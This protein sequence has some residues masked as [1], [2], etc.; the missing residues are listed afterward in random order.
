M[1]KYDER[2]LNERTHIQSEIS[3]ILCI[4]LTLSIFIKFF[5]L[6]KALSDMIIELICSGMSITYFILR[7]LHLGHAFYTNYIKIKNVIIMVVITSVGSW[8]FSG[9]TGIKSLLIMLILLGGI[10]ST[11]HFILYHINKKRQQQIDFEL[12]QG[13]D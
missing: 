13:L 1:I 4:L 8:F 6:N 12:D 10:F 2:T 11:T 7:S 5:Y 9:H 3:Q